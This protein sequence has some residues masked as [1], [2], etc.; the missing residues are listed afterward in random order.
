MPTQTYTPIARQ[1]LASATATVTFSS[2][3]GTYTDL[4][5]VADNVGSSASVVDLRMRLNGNSTSL[6]SDTELFGNGSSAL[7]DRHSNTTFAKLAYSGGS[8]KPL[9][10]ANI[11]NYSNATTNKTVLIRDSAPT[12]AIVTRVCL[13]RNTAAI[14]SFEISYSSGNIAAG[15]TFTLYGIKA[16]S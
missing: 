12:N 13:Y 3:S 11:M 9:V 4:V 1:E 7:S 16:G 8:D 5:L 15:A 2:I 14:T 10:I 6:Y